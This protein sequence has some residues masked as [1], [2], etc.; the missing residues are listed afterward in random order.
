MVAAAPAQAL[1]AV[2]AHSAFVAGDI[3]EFCCVHLVGSG[4]HAVCY[5]PAISTGW[6]SQHD[7]LL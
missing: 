1:Q 7:D 4:A 3:C 2:Q 5:S 6:H